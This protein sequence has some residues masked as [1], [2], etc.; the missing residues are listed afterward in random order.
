MGIPPDRASDD[1]AL[2]AALSLRIAEQPLAHWRQELEGSS[3]CVS[4]VLDYQEVAR[5]RLHRE[6][7]MIV[8]RELPG[9][10]V[11]T[12]GQAIRLDGLAPV[13]ESLAPRFSADA[14]ALLMDLGYDAEQRADLYRADVVRAPATP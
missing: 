13:A 4:G 12:T 6:R 11:V 1:E 2:G 10:A 7:G 8:W 5:E 3:L 14:D 9:G